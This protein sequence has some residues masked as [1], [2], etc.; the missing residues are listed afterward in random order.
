[1]ARITIP[2]CR[3]AVGR[4]FLTAV[5]FVLLGSRFLPAQT[6]QPTPTASLLGEVEAWAMLFQM[7]SRLEAAVQKG[8]L[9]LIDPEDPVAS[10]AVSSLLAEA[11]KKP[12]PRIGLLKVQWIQFVRGISAL[13]SASDAADAERAAKQMKLSKEQF[14]KLQETAD[15]KV[16]E[17]AHK[18]AERF[19][20]PMH[21][22]ITRAK[23]EAC[24][25]CGM[26][27]DQPVVLLPSL[28]LPLTMSAHT[29]VATIT[30][31]GPL[32]PGKLAHAT[33]HLRRGGNHTVTLD[34]LI[35]THTKK[36]HLLIVDQ[37][38]TDYHHEHP[39]PTGT[40][41][42]YSFEFT[43]RKPGP[44]LAW[45]DLR[46]LPLGL[47]EYDKT[48]IAGT[49]QPEPISDKVTKLSADAEGLHFELTPAA[50]EIKAGVPI[51][52]KLRVTRNGREFNQ[53]EPVM[54]A[55]AHLVGFNEDR[56]TVIH[57]HPMG[58]QLLKESDRGGPVL[59]FKIY[60][61]KPGFIRLFAQVQIDGRQVFAPF[62]L[63][64]TK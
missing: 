16:L 58:A 11:S 34:Q 25:K 53:L 30:T 64:V 38:L 33:L 21:P 42:D 39:Q 61:T 14:R 41:G 18:L 8:E 10:A 32:L 40:D 1:M 55:F 49:G 56:E 4:A 3:D 46:P 60:A 17:R 45:A 2:S 44:Y 52:A 63:Q 48:I 26:P 7:M 9:T 29:V 57:M 62:G 19:T 20:C 35:E 27:L 28:L 5:V 43:P 23:G 36:I 54:G 51:G 37:S 31:D 12:P 24:P 22:E 59:E 13:H 6:P 15:P 50:P 47:Q